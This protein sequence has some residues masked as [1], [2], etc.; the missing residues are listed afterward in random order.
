MT[1]EKVSG[2]RIS[3]TY[4]YG[5]SIIEDKHLP[6]Q[7]CINSDGAIWSFQAAGIPIYSRGTENKAQVA[8]SGTE[9]G[10]YS[11]APHEYSFSY[12]ESCKFYR[13][14]IKRHSYASPKGISK[15]KGAWLREVV[16]DNCRCITVLIGWLIVRFHKSINYWYRRR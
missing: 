6:R 13:R 2:F 1:Y 11:Q 3:R 10:I 15:K 8:S 14:I 4:Q 16:K 12:Q 5:D 7:S 9:R